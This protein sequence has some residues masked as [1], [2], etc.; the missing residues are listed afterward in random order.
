MLLTKVWNVTLSRTFCC[1]FSSYRKTKFILSHCSMSFEYKILAVLI[2]RPVSTILSF[3]FF[4]KSIGFKWISL[5]YSQNSSNQVH[6]CV[7]F[8]E[9][10]ILFSV[11]FHSNKK[12]VLPR[13]NHCNFFSYY[14]W[15]VRYIRHV[16]IGKG[17]KESKFQS[18]DVLVLSSRLID[19]NC[20]L[21][22]VVNLDNVTDWMPV[23]EIFL[24]M[25]I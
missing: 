3:Y 6:F 14:S 12:F 16:L 8:I 22:V 20:S 24:R 10:D 23:N 4:W 7:L 13:Q 17:N 19:K 11:C 9:N 21:C 15:N 5:K 1:F 2:C 18:K 25:R